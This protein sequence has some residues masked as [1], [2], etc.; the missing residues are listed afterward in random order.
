MPLT[1][2]TPLIADNSSRIRLLTNLMWVAIGVN[3][4]YKM[5]K[6]IRVTFFEINFMGGNLRWRPIFKLCVGRGA[7]P[8][9]RGG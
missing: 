2:L 5:Q 1:P 8:F 3:T 7:G 9:R 6:E 4:F